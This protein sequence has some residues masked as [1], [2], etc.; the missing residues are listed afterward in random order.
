MI[1]KTGI[2]I[3]SIFTL[4]IFLINCATMSKD[5]CLHADWYI[6]GLDDASDG[7]ALDRISDHA[8]AC[9]R[10]D[11]K[12]NAQDYENGHKKGARL[13]CVPNKGYSEGRKGVS[14]NGIC[15]ASL[16]NNFLRAYRDGQELFSIQQKM[17]QLANDISNSRSQIDS[18]Y[19]EIH[20]LK[21]DIIDRDSNSQERRYKLR[22][23]DDLQDE[24]TALDI[25]I[26]RDAREIELFQ[27]DYRILE[28]KHY[29]MGYLIEKP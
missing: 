13:Y 26:D 20:A 3:G 8:K 28:D 29:R 6:K 19:N 4:A 15:P 24:A 1:I 23:I 5:E 21:H 10:V 22:R 11:I 17:D 12:P 25:R 9:A 2:K 7:Y 27:N 16:E 14:Y 18:N